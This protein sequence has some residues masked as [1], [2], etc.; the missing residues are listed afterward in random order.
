MVSRAAAVSLGGEW[1][2]S[3]TQL[4]EHANFFRSISITK[5]MLFFILSLMVAVAA[6]N[7]VSTMV[8]VVKDKRRDIAILRTFGAS[9]RSI[10]SI[11]VVQGSLV[12]MLGIAAGV[13]MGVLIAVNLQQLV[14][15]L[16]ASSAS[17]FSMRACT[18]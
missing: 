5:R 7:I 9:P 10:L 3:E 4:D 16:K 2:V 15:G 11:F 1:E 13:L 17:S 14:H 8:M 12:G 18:S 6:F